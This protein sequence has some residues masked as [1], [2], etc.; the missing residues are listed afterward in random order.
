[1]Y[2]SFTWIELGYWN[3]PNQKYVLLHR[4]LNLI[5]VLYDNSHFRPIP[6]RNGEKY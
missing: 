2:V 4:E 3:S 5:L 6:M 1:M